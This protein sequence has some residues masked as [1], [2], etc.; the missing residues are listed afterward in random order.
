MDNIKEST[1]FEKPNLQRVRKG[2]LVALLVDDRT[3][4]ELATWFHQKLDKRRAYGSETAAKLYIYKY[5][6]LQIS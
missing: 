4:E 3:V 2:G 1:T 6:V 5:E